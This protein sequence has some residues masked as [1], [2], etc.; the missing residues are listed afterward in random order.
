MSALYLT[1][2]ALAVS[3]DN[4]CV[5]V[6][7]GIRK[8]KLPINANLIISVTSGT[9]I[10]LS[11]M[12]GS[13]ITNYLSV[14]TARILGASIILL[15]GVWIILQ[16]WWQKWKNGIAEEGAIDIRIE[17]L[18]IVIRILNDPSKADFD[19]SGTISNSE[20]VVLGVAL[21]LNALGAG[22]GAAMEG[23]SP[24][25]TSLAVAILS[26]CLI[27]LGVQAGEKY[28]ASWLGDRIAIVSGAVLIL[29]GIWE[30]FS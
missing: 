11:M 21:A 13:F 24:L 20:A 19:C 30:L 15:T 3:L 18:G 12:A 1:L 27:A 10:L 6:A 14:H 25:L 28:M 5:G 4:F 23:L 2:L 9:A 22:F 29:L 17:S 26:F 7:Y 16:A 8:I